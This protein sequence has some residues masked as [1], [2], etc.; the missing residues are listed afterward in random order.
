MTI[1]LFFIIGIKIR[2]ATSVIFGW[3]GIHQGIMLYGGK[4]MF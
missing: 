4:K 1:L 3:K 2:R